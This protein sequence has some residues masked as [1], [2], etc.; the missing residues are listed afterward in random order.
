MMFKIGQEHYDEKRPIDA[1]RAHVERQKMREGHLY[2]WPTAYGA[3]RQSFEVY[4]GK[5]MTPA[6]A[7]RLRLEKLA[8]EG[9]R[10]I[11]EAARKEMVRVAAMPARRLGSK[12]AVDE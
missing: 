2:V 4:D 5:V 11:V 7:K 6:A 1:A 3:R 8:V 12:K 9:S 10:K